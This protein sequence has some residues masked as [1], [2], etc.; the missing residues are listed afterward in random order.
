MGEPDFI[1]RVRKARISVTVNGPE[2]GGA[3]M[4]RCFDWRL[5][6][7]DA[8]PEE[9]QKQVVYIPGAF[10]DFAPG[11]PIALLQEAAARGVPLRVTA[12]DLPEYQASRLPGGW[13]GRVAQAGDLSV[14]SRLLQAVLAHVAPGP[15]T[16]ISWSTGAVHATTLAA[17]APEQVEAILLCM[18]AGF[19]R[20]PAL[21]RLVPNFTR[22]TLTTLADADARRA[23]QGDRGLEQNLE[24]LLS[25]AKL[26]IIVQMSGA[27]ARDAAVA[28]AAQVRCPVVFV[29]GRDDIVFDKLIALAEQGALQRLFPQ[30]PAVDVHI[31]DGATHN[32]FATHSAK[33]AAITL[34]TIAREAQA[35]E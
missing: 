15:H 11:M 10:A 1:D 26:P 17:W 7:W 19:F 22:T 34:D 23:V 14:G 25:L 3:A 12:I 35:H 29:L 28:Y 2:W 5:A 30:A 27:L 16:I 18:P 24:V 20:Q 9:E 21:S 4:V 33:I 32:G 6:D 13:V 8:V 31:L